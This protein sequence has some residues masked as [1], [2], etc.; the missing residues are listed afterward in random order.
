MRAWPII[1]ARTRMAG[2]GRDRDRAA[3]A[4]LRDPAHLWGHARRRAESGRLVEGRA[5]G[6]LRKHARLIFAWIFLCAQ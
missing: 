2:G 4:R 3:P 1:S 5:A 6:D